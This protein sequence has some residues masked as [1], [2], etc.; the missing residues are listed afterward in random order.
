MTERY[1][2]SPDMQTFIEESQRFPAEG[3]GLAAQRDAYNRLCRAYTPPRPADLEV[4]DTQLGGV[5]VRLYRPQSETPDPGWP[6]IL[7]LHGGGWIVGNLDSHEFLTA[8]LALRL[9]ATV[10]A[11][12]YRLAPEHPFPAPLDDCLTAWHGLQAQAQDYRLNLQRLAVAG[13][14][15]GGTLA[16]ALCL[17]LRDHGEPMPCAQALI[18]PLLTAASLLSETRYADAPLLS[19]KEVHECLAAYLPHA[20]DHNNPLAMPLAAKN[21]SDLPP[22]FIAVSE[23]DPLHDHGVQYRS[24]LE[25]AGILVRFHE[26][27][28][29][30]H[31]SLRAHAPEAQGLYTALVTALSSYLHV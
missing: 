7:Y 15:A 19:A 30:V 8:D 24:R 17:A 6:G 29:L 27:T 21:L 31:G 12:D 11:V 4:I 28:G 2:L 16:A 1:P 9:N 23:F 26:G 5:P 10:I 13:D 14:S 25:E 22:A 18:Y 3:P 20:A